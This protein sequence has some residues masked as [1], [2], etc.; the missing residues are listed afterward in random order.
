MLQDHYFYQ[1]LGERQSHILRLKSTVQEIERDFNCLS[2]AYGDIKRLEIPP[3]ETTNYNQTIL[4]LNAMY[5]KILRSI[6]N[7]KKRL[8]L[9]EKAAQNDY[10]AYAMLLQDQGMELDYVIQL[11]RSRISEL[12]NRYRIEYNGIE[13]QFGIS[14][15]MPPN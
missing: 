12:Q 5:Q 13:C 9:F 10:H 1:E 15:I 11:G 14:I 7:L 3:L 2:D 6:Y 8:E 4:E